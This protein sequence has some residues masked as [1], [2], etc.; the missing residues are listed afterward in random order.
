MTRGYKPRRC[1]KRW[2]DGDCP[3]EVLAIIRYANTDTYGGAYDVIYNDVQAV[4]Y[5]KY[6]HVEYWLNGFSVNV[7]GASI[8]HFEM[9][10]HQVAAYRYRFKH[11]YAKWSTLPA[12]VKNTVR[13]DI[14]AAKK[15]AEENA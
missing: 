3:D 1:S 8:D 4:Q 10:A 9:Q 13:A 11:R 6:S 5:G 14:A 2:L 12:A 15:W 7:S